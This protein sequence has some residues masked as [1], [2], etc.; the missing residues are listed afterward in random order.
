MKIK[1]TRLEAEKERIKGAKE[2]YK[3]NKSGYALFLLERMEYY[4]FLT[5]EQYGRIVTALRT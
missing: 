3:D 4:G 1:M 5:Q 2:F